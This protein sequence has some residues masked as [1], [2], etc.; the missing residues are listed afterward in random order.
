MP[1]MAG[2]AAVATKEMLGLT[3]LFQ[4]LPRLFQVFTM[5][6]KMLKNPQVLIETPWAVDMYNLLLYLLASHVSPLLF[7]PISM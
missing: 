5:T 6:S 3:V 4:Y 2:S 7:S 1:K